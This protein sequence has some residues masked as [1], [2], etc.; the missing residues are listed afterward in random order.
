VRAGHDPAEV[1]DPVSDSF[2]ELG[3]SGMALG[4][5]DA[6]SYQQYQECGHC[7]K[8]I[9]LIGTDGIWETENP[10]GERF[11]KERLRQIVRQHR[12]SSAGGMIDAVFS[13]IADFRQASVQADD[14][15]LVVVKAKE[16]RLYT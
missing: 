16:V 7:G 8:E 1:Y 6:W 14:I 15:T 12:H 10:L 3:G 4:V 11:G 9:I 2:R 5:D 13:A